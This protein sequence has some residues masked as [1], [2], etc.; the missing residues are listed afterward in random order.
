MGTHG[1]HGLSRLL[2]GSIAETVLRYSR[3]P[4]LALRHQ[5]TALRGEPIRVILHPT[6]FSSG[7]E[8]SLRAARRLARETGARL[9]VLHVTP[10]EI[11]VE[12]IG[13]VG[14]DQ[15]ADRD[16]LEAIRAR[17]E[18]PDLKCPVEVRLG[19]GEP[20]A[21]ILRVADELGAGLI[22]MGTQGRTG[23]ERILMG[24]VAEAVLRRARCPV[25][26]GRSPL[27]R[28]EAGADQPTPRVKVVF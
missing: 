26:I 9:I 14:V 12:G 5:E 13:A 24:S 7:S 6:D 22:V 8:A 27:P 2:A 10:P 20:A 15:R 19:R 3:C 4:V 17:I 25:L 11:V 21:E 1:R 23:L 28:P 18:G 16:A